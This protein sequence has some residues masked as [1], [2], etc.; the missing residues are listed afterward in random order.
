[1]IMS[2]VSEKVLVVRTVASCFTCGATLGPSRECPLCPLCD[3]DEREK[4][5]DYCAEQ[6]QARFP[7]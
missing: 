6:Q 7:V 4:W 3:Q 2:D 1:M 5:S